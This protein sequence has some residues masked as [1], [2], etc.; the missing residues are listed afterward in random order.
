MS[1]PIFAVF[2]ATG[3]QG[4][5][6]ANFVLSD[7]ELSQRYA[8]RAVSRDTSNPKMQALKSKGASLAQ[9]DLDDPSSLPAALTDVSYLFFI[10]TTQYQGNS[11]EIETR[12]AKSL[13]TAA[14]AAGVKYI[15][16]SSMSHPFKISAGALKHVEHFD[17]KAEIEQYIRSLP[18]QSSF[19]APAS[20]MQNF[21]TYSGPKP[22]GDGTY[23]ISNILHPHTKVPFIDIADTGKWIG[24]ILADPEKYSGKFFAAGEGLYTMP[25][26]CELMSKVSGKTIRYQQVEDEVYKGFL[27][28]VMRQPYYEMWVLNR[29]YGYYGEGQE[30]L[31]E[32][33]KEQARG[34][35]T[36]LEEW[37]VREKFDVE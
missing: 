21:T 28:P 20:F 24:A 32:W 30:E 17:A 29:E 34:R 7:P 37:L 23:A 12:Q 16:F 2:G 3:N 5:S 35:V 33:A 31:V 18:V 9:A 13:C 15:I 6:A 11:R 8:V 27:T 22:V 4:N 10:T 25:Q 26:A 14:L 19:F 36:G 1:K